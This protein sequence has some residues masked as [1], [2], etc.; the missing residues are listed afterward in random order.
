MDGQQ[1]LFERF[2]RNECTAAEI[3]ALLAQFNEAANEAGL[4][5]LIAAELRKGEARI[6]PALPD[7]EQKEAAIYKALLP[8]IRPLRKPSL[9]PRIAA[10]ASIAVFLG[11]GGY[12]VFHKKQAPVQLA[13]V[14]QPDI[15]PGQNRA[16]LTLANGH[17][18]MLAKGLKGQL[19]VQNGTV[20]RASDQDISYHP[21]NTEETVSYNTLATDKGEQSPYPLV[22]ADGTRVWLDAASS[23][24]FPTAFTG[25]ERLV[26]VTGQAYFEV[27]HNAAQPF[28]IAVGDL[29]IQD[30]GTEFNIN[31]YGDEP[32]VRTTLVNGAVSVSKAGR[33]VLLKPGQVAIA[34][35]TLSVRQANIE[36]ATAWK[37]GYFRYES[38]ELKELMKQVARWYNIEVVYECRVPQHDFFID[39]KRRTNLSNM[40]EILKQGGVHFR[41]D[42][43]KLT[44]TQ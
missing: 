9:W 32:A 12:L 39:T 1:E 17:K 4:R 31:A 24:T 38:I 41:M 6:D 3:E 33:S 11:V 36:E 20:I 35:T 25:K 2:I 18:I 16:T 15:A 27:V 21:T 8:Q 13:Q 30:I 34:A 42:G 23:I 19:A 40:L 5:A 14:R 43:R 7:L 26:K 44:I 37:N 22:L 29:T 28:K 10:A